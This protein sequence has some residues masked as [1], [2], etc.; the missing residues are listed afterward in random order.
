MANVEKTRDGA[1]HPDTR[2]VC[3]NRVLF[4]PHQRHIRFSLEAGNVGRHRAPVIL[5]PSWPL[6]R[7]RAAW[8]YAKGII[9]RSDASPYPAQSGMQRGP[10]TE[11]RS[12]RARCLLAL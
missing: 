12:V 8:A 3:R 4:S 10:P 2:A 6:V 11:S 9:G 7:V 5:Y 1:R